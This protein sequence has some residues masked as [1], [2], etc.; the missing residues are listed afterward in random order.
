MTDFFSLCSRL[1][2]LSRSFWNSKSFHDFWVNLLN[3]SFRFRILQTFSRIYQLKLDF[4]WKF[5]LKKKKIFFSL[6]FFSETTKT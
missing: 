4:K 1:S 2:F 5:W 6:K 3:V